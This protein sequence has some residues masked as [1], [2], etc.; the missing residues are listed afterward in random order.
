MTRYHIDDTEAQLWF[1][2][3]EEEVDD[4]SEAVD[5]HLGTADRRK[6]GHP[7]KSHGSWSPNNPFTS[8]R[9]RKAKGG[10]TIRRSRPDDP[11]MRD[12]ET[13]TL[14]ER[15]KKVRAKGPAPKKIADV[16]KSYG[17][18]TVPIYDR[19]LPEW[20]TDTEMRIY[21]VPDRSDTESVHLQ[22]KYGAYFFNQM[23][24]SPWRGELEAGGGYA[25]R[26]GNVHHNTR[27]VP[28]PTSRV[29]DMGGGPPTKR[30]PDPTSI[31]YTGPVNALD[32]GMMRQIAEAF[33][34]AQKLEASFDRETYLR[35]KSP[36]GDTFELAPY[37]ENKDL[38][39][40]VKF[41][42]KK[43]GLKSNWTG[44]LTIGRAD[45]V[46]AWGA[47]PNTPY[48]QHLLLN[49]R[50]AQGNMDGY[51]QKAMLHE[52][53]HSVSPGLTNED[54]LNEGPGWEEAF[55]EG[56]SRHLWPELI[57]ELRK[58]MG[59]D[60]PGYERMLQRGREANA[61]PAYVREA[62]RAMRALEMEPDDFYRWMMRM[63]ITGRKEALRKAGE[64]KFGEGDGY[65]T[66]LMNKLNGTL[67]GSG[68]D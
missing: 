15:P 48:Y 26:V 36:E 37:V 41:A 21:K 9:V 51:V 66:F 67:K 31:E 39:P 55:V 2:E 14:Y 16:Q 1:A 32:S 65:W 24:G 3:E 63:P 53:L 13:G 68:W 62:E 29:P 30:I 6:G 49:A 64:E 28:D 17:D 45:F 35:K 52:S 46:A 40:M 4:L 38:V 22:Y 47:D 43:T 42:E 23:D 20:G 58:E 44:R 27:R 11:V 34:T 10:L 7:Q 18:G 12:R 59:E 57:P 56:Y 54:Y 61:Y 33:P 8:A 50:Y 5:L 19:P 25:S 60:A